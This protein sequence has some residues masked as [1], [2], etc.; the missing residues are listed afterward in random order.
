MNIGIYQ[1]VNA[2]APAIHWWL[3]HDSRFGPQ[4]YK[5]HMPRS[6]ELFIGSIVDELR[7]VNDI[8]IDEELYDSHQE[9]LRM[10][11]NKKETIDQI[12]CLSE[13][14][15]FN[16][17][18]K[19][20]VWSNYFGSCYSP[21]YAPL[22]DKLIFA[23]STT[24]QSAMFY[25]TQ[26]AFDIM[27]IDNVHDHSKIWW[28]DHVLM[29]GKDIG[30]WKEIWYNNYHDQC[31]AD[32]HSGK[33]Q[34]MWQLNFAH[35]DL[36][37]SLCDGGDGKFELD[38]SFYRLFKDKHDPEDIKTQNKVL[39]NIKEKDIDHLVVDIE[40]FKNTDVIL[41][42]LGISNSDILKHTAQV[43]SERYKKV[44]EAYNILYN[45]YYVKGEQ[46]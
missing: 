7:N 10:M 6:S 19:Y 9:S 42:Y 43:Y 3:A 17:D 37:E 23:Q 39:L 46:V 36:Y 35:W 26:Y 40:W 13:Y 8:N 22:A 33:L 28:E 12:D 18:F 41:D 4:L 24:E 11:E 29:G 5:G 15:K 1:T 25:I 21:H 30:K 31:V 16:K 44:A 27:N 32:F 45:K 2:H 20:P 34:Y 38:Y 14:F